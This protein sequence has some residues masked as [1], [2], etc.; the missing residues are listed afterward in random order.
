MVSLLKNT[1]FEKVGHEDRFEFFTVSVEAK[2]ALVNLASIFVV[3]NELNDGIMDYFVN[4]V[5][6][7]N[8]AGVA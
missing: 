5:H 4:V 2:V 1:V 6:I 7:V 8:N 3:S